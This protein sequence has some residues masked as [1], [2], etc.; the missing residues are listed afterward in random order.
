MDSGWWTVFTNPDL[1]WS[2]YAEVLGGGDVISG[3]ILPYFFNSFAIA[4]PAAIFPL[5]L[6][7]MAAYALA[8]MP[9][10]GATSIFFIIFALIFISLLFIILVC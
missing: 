6:A 1:T 10:K 3:G 2:N 7:T 5:V 8:W 9:F 4:I